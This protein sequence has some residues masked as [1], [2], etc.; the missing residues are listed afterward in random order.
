MKPIGKRT[1]CNSSIACG[2]LELLFVLVGLLTGV[3]H[4]T[5]KHM[6]SNIWIECVLVID[7]IP[8]QSF[9]EQKPEFA[10]VFGARPVYAVP[11]M[12]LNYTK[13]EPEPPA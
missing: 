7:T 4:A 1:F 11:Y 2:V 13:I 5:N 6:I 12:P 3:A 9:I 8:P 10:Q